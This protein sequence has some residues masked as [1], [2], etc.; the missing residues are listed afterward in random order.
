ML[1]LLPDLDLSVGF[2]PVPFSK[3]GLC[4]K[5]ILKSLAEH[6]LTLIKELYEIRSSSK[7]DEKIK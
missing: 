6:H 2:G 5:K 1:C 3:R 7:L 4:N